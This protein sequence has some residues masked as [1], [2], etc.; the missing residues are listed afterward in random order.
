[1][2]QKDLNLRQRRWLELLKEYELVIDYYPRKLTLSDNEL[3]AKPLF[4]KQIYEAQKCDNELQARRVQCES[5]TY[6]DYQIGSDDCLMFQGRI[7]VPKNSELIQ[8]IL[9]E[10]HNGCLSVY[11]GSI[12]MYNDL[13]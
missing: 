11:L 2:T 12:K 9:H 3:K 8:E 5:T 4:L 10:A 13:K 6:S 1:M 7:C